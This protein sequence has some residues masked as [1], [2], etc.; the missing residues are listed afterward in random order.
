MDVQEVEGNDADEHPPESSALT[1]LVT[2]AK[3]VERRH[4]E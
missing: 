2:S 4:I 3:L 1:M